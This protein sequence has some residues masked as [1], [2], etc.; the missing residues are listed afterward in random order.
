MPW[1]APRSGMHVYMWI[2]MPIAGS[3]DVDAPQRI[4]AE[5]FSIH[6]MS[7]TLGKVA[8]GFSDILVE[9]S[10]EVL[11]SCN[12]RMSSAC[13]WRWIPAGTGEG[14]HR[15]VT[16]SHD[17]WQQLWVTCSKRIWSWRCHL[18]TRPRWFSSPLPNHYHHPY[19]FR[20]TQY[21]YIIYHSILIA[22]TVDND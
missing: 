16:S 19:Y 11:S 12:G 15:Q 18:P 10:R 1:I 9:N 4:S 22:P 13:R 2:V 20:T 6:Q 14:S 5:Q 17:W 21:F 7:S 8:G 3:R